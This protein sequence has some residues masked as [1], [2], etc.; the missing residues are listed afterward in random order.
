MPAT[1]LR[2][3][4]SIYIQDFLEYYS[5]EDLCYQNSTIE[6]VFIEIDKDQIGKD[7]NAIIG[8]IYRPPNGDICSFNDYMSEILTKIKCERKYVSCL[9]DYNISLLNYDTHGPTQEFADLL[10]SNSLLPCITKPTRVTAKSASLIDIFCNSVLYDDHAF[11]GILYTDI[12]DHFPVFYID[13]TS[14]TKNPSLYFKKRTFSEQNVNQFSLKLRDRNW[15]DL[16]ACNGPEIA[17]T[18]FSN[19]IT[20]PFDTCFPLRTV[21]HGYKTRKP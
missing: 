18:V 12:S 10:Y 16:L 9:G 21:K 2:R 15:S 11:T 4:V 13:G 1:S 7:K 14:Q 6:S 20:E 8:V 19:T 17:Y 3:G 5:R